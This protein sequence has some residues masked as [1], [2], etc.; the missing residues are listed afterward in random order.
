MSDKTVDVVNTPILTILRDSGRA[1]LGMHA[2]KQWFEDPKHLLFSMSR[3]KFVAKMLSGKSR[4]LEIGCGDGFNARL[5]RQEVP[6]LTLTDIDPLFVADAVKLRTKEWDYEA[7]VH[8]IVEGPVP[9]RFDAIYTLDVLE[10]IPA[11]LEAKFLRHAIASLT[12]DGVMIV[13]MPSKESQAFSKPVSVTGHINCKSQPELKKLL[14]EYFDNVFM[15]S[16]NDEVV[17][18]GFHKT[19]NYLMAVCCGMKAARV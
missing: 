19:A 1:P 13:G 16:M 4:A 12:P 9:G 18:T 17:H 15:F 10:H 14:Q 6:S 2:N 11:E 8:N 3:Y 7:F 5:V